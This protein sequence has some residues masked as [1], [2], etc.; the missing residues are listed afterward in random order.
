MILLDGKVV[1]NKILA[2]IKEQ[3][4]RYRACPILSV[5]L[6]TDDPASKVY[7]NRKIKACEEVGI[8][9]RLILPHHESSWEVRKYDLLYETIARQ[10]DFPVNG[11]LVQLPLPESFTP[12]KH[13]LLDCI[14]PMIDV[15]V[16]T[17]TNVGML[18]QGR[19]RFL[20]C[21]PHGIYRLMRYY[22]IEP[23]KRKVLIINRSDVVGKPLQSMLIQDTYKVGHEET[24]YTGNATVTM[25][26]DHT[27]PIMLK[28]ICQDSDIIIVAVGKRNFLTA[29]MIRPGAVVIDV[30]INRGEDGKIYGD[31]DFPNVV[32][33]AAAITP[34]PGGVGPCTVAML[35]YNTWQAYKLKNE[36]W[37]EYC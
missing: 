8:R 34:V 17:S 20:P 7:V 22:G 4:A 30:G 15:D 16:F 37:T 3:I 9:G 13:T 29:D 33:K 18:L 25:C 28:E 14:D 24:L 26:H 6:T 2:D 11:V 10:N 31:A 36:I 1:A 35:M 19:P 23:A 12:Y 27:P 5:I 21:T 32:Q